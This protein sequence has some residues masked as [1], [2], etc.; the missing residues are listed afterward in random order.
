MVLKSS[1]IHRDRKKKVWLL[2]AEGVGNRELSLNGD[3]VS[4]G[5]DEKIP[6]DVMVVMVAQ[7]SECT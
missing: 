7:Q 6:G 2:G 3:G 5:D 4:V 1:Q